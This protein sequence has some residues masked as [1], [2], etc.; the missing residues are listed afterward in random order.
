MRHIL[1]A[2]CAAWLC[3]GGIEAR[4]EKPRAEKPPETVKIQGQVVDAQGAAVGAAPSGLGCTMP[5]RSTR[6][7]MPTASSRST[8]PK[9]TPR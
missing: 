1:F 8:C 7:P 9:H 4:A 3:R 5:N 2:I 6:V